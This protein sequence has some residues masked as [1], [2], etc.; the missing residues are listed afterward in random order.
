[1]DIVRRNTDYAL[2]A[3]VNLAQNHQKEPISSR[4]ISQ[5]E[6]V[7]YQ[8][9]NKLLQ[10]LNKARLIKS[11]MGPKGGFVLER[12]PSKINL[13]EIIEAVQLP[14]SLN[15]CLLSK[16]ACPRQKVCT[17]RQKLNGL[18]EYMEEYLKNITLNELVNDKPAKKKLT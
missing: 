8:L 1:M 7:P 13:Q 5:Q 3:M 10:K 6:G 15:R 11:Y 4:T 18:Q 17:I 16:D 12:E 2:R 14:I 9:M